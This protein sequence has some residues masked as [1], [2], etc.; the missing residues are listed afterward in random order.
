MGEKVVC[1]KAYCCAPTYVYHLSSIWGYSV[2]E[3]RFPVNLHIHIYIYMRT[4]TQTQTQDTGTNT[5]IDTDT[6]TDTD[7]N[8][9]HLVLN[10]GLQGS[11]Q[12][13]EKRI[14]E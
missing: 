10:I 11:E 6:D 2:P 5:D 7:T 8:I 12:G 9:Y 3:K 14:P 4:Q 1:E 13:L